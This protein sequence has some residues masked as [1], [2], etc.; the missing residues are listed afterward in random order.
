M[1]PCA[2][3]LQNSTAVTIIF[4]W[5]FIWDI[6]VVEGWGGWCFENENLYAA[7]IIMHSNLI[8]YNIVVHYSWAF[9]VN[10]EQM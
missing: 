6:F 4:S 2:L 1:L 3:E 7:K 5:G 8:V 10:V 9:H